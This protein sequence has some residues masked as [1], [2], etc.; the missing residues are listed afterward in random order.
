MGN[1][2]NIDISIVILTKNPGSSFRATLEMIFSQK[3]WD[4]LKS[5]LWIPDLTRKISR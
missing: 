5:L 1:D 2:E 3:K 4:H